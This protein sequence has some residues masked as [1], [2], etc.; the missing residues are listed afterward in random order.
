MVSFSLSLLF[1]TFLLLLWFQW[2]CGRHSL[3][4]SLSPLSLSLVTSMANFPPTLP[5]FHPIFPWTS[6]RERERREER[7]NNFDQIVHHYRH[8]AGLCQSPDRSSGTRRI[9]LFLV[10][11]LET[12][13]SQL[14]VSSVRLPTGCPL[15]RIGIPW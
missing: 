13:Y 14:K 7:K 6:D 11:L 3:S 8:C 2:L 15:T 12:S 1:Y 9:N 4:L 10:I 5:S